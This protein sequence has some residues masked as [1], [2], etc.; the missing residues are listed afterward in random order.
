MTVTSFYA[1]LV[2]LFV[3]RSSACSTFVAGKKASKDGS[4]M[5]TQSADGEFG[6]DSRLCYVP[7]ADHAPNATRPVYFAY[8]NY[9]RFVGKGRGACYEAA[10][11]KPYEA[12]GQIP[13]VAH[14]YAFF[15]GTFGILN[16][17]GLGIGET[18]CSGMFAALP[19]SQGG[20]ALMS[21]DELTHIALERTSKARDAVALMGEL[22]EK[23]GFYGAS[24]HLHNGAESLMVGDADEAF[25]FHVLA[26]PTGKSAIWVAQRVPDDHVG[27]VTNMF[28]IRDLDFN[29]SHNF[30]IGS[31]VQSVAQEKGWWKPGRTMD[32]TATYSHG[33]YTSKYYSGHRMWDAYRHFGIDLPDTYG[34][35]KYD[36]VYPTT[37]PAARLLTVQD[38]FATHRSHYEGT[39]YD[40]TKG[41]AA[42]PFGDPD[43]WMP[44]EGEKVVGN[45]ERAIG[46]FRTAYTEVV[47]L[48]RSGQGSLM[49]FAPHASASSCFVPFSNRM[50]EVPS[51]YM[52]A[53]PDPEGLS[54][55]SA[56]W[57]HR[58]VFTVAKIMYNHAMSNVTAVQKELEDAGVQLV[59]DIDAQFDAGNSMDA[60]KLSAMYTKHAERVLRAFW[61]LPD[62]IVASYSDGWLADKA[63]VGYPDWWLKAVGYE[64]GP[65]AIPPAYV[66][67]PSS[68]TAT[69]SPCDDAGIRDCISFCPSAGF[70]ACAVRCTRDC[71]SKQE[72]SPVLV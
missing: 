10:G 64:Q 69:R 54:R 14:T 7:A 28:T 61:A 32:F 47:Q 17:H 55:D 53:N 5:L 40:L 70:A 37:V 3:G 12:M 62:L 1:V 34:N 51:M 56:Y 67:S 26:D 48:K 35:L 27:A 15:E 21:I 58:Y 49:W 4:V 8:E 25:I 52:S 11:Q 41:L 57:A 72:S 65:P 20:Q 44:K 19:I 42:G 59:A 36:K 31:L 60:T 22:A 63:N 45:W 29:D 38:L 2:G 6:F 30:L 46:I 9:P 33:E 13:Q 24:G 68:V 39:K 16:E 66:A 18:T 71:E 43:R 50:T 23:Y